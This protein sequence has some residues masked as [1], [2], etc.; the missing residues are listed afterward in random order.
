MAREKDRR[1]ASS[2]AETINHLNGAPFIKIPK[3]TRLE[4]CTMEIDN[5]RGVITVSHAGRV[6]FHVPRIPLR[7]LALAT[8][9]VVAGAENK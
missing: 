4:N 3:V 9:T 8:I 6:K 7:R 5:A 2:R 1:V